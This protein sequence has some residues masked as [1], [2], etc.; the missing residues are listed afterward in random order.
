MGIGSG[1]VYEALKKL[2][3]TDKDGHITVDD[4]T[5][6]GGTALT[7]HDLTDHITNI[8]VALSTKARLQPWYQSNFKSQM[9]YYQPNTLA[10]HASTTRWTY[11]VAASR[12]AQVM[13]AHA[14][15]YRVTAP[16]TA[17]AATLSIYASDGTNYPMIVEVRENTSTTDIHKLNT[18][19]IG[20]I[21]TAGETITCDTS[22]LSVTGTYRMR[23][24]AVF[25]EFDT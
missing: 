6:W 18:Q 21:L 24:S 13:S 10:P 17:G 3:V 20:P 1:G 5:K 23:G 25:M 9:N 8:D 19:G 14:S 7:G 15:I 2:F 22:D 11:T 12:I 16:G 4:L